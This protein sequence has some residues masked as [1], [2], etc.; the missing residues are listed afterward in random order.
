[1]NLAGQKIGGL[2]VETVSSGG[3]F[4]L[5][6][7]LGFNVLNHPRRFS[8][9]EHLSQGLHEAPE[10]SE[11][12]QFLDEL[13]AELAGALADCV[14]P[15]LNKAACFDLAQ[16]LNANTSRPFVVERVGRKGDLIHAG[17]RVPWTDL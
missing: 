6:V 16:A 15:E 12:F 2:L 3:K 8:T 14:L 4:R 11:W 17:G 1:L 13:R 10:E 7:G 5:L 9:A